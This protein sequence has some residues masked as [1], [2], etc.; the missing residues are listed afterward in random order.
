MSEYPE[1]MVAKIAE[2]LDNDL[3]DEPVWS[4]IVIA[5]HVLDAL[6]LSEEVQLL[7]WKCHRRYVTDW[8]D[9]DGQA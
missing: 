9:A 7:N 5:K 6:G 8:E 3:D 4:Q 2:V 1:A